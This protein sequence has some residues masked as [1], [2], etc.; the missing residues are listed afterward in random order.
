M[1]YCKSCRKVVSD[2]A[3]IC[4]GCGAERPGEGAEERAA[5]QAALDEAAGRGRAKEVRF[6]EARGQFLTLAGVVAVVALLAFLGTRGADERESDDRPGG[7][8]PYSQCEDAVRERLANPETAD[9]TTLATENEETD[10]GWIIRGEVK[11]ETGF[12]V[13]RKLIF[14]CEAL[15]DGTI[16]SAV[17]QE[18]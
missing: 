2:G 4:P 16:S 3:A 17:V 6:K 13:E 5:G 9:F 8:P 1:T 18:T 10:T 14:Q 7:A 15:F 11:A 12:G